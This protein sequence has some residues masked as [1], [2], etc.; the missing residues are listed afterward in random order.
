MII[1]TKGSQNRIIK[2]IT[3]AEKTETGLFIED[4][5]DLGYCG[6]K[7][8]SDVDL[9]RIEDCESIVFETTTEPRIDPKYITYSDSFS[10]CIVIELSPVI[11]AE[12]VD[13]NSIEITFENGTTKT[14]TG[15][16]TC[17]YTY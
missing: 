1:E 17:A 11:E 15:T 5:E 10:D 4:E 16:L 3:L 9:Y 12:Q 7:R 13:D 14:I 2:G 6:K 8:L